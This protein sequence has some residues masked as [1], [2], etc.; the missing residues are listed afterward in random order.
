MKKTL[1]LIIFVLAILCNNTYALDNGNL[2][3]HFL[4]VGEG[5][6][7]LIQ[8]PNAKTVLVDAGNLITGHKVAEY[9]KNNSIFNLD[10]LIFTHPDLD[11]IGGAFFIMQMLKVKRVYD[12]GND[13]E[14]IS[15]RIDVYSWYNDLTRNS[16]K[17]NILNEGDNFQL[18]GVDFEILS[19]YKPRLSSG[20]NENSIVIMIKYKGFKCLLMG[21]ATSPVERQLLRKEKN[22]RADILKVGHHG[23]NDAS[24]EAFIKKVLPQASIISVNKDNIRGRPAKDVVTRLIDAGSRVYRTDRNGD[25]IIKIDEKGKFKISYIKK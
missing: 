7:I 10:Y 24:S 13:L 11:H 17:Y 8:T 25:I 6:S 15:R 3:V 23:D 16:S 2:E 9:L 4:D 1:F 18:D 22:L 21:D 12:N 20:F 19:S 14:G 5:D